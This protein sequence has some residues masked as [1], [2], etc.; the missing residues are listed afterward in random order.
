MGEGNQIIG[1]VI[2]PNHLYL[3]LYLHEQSR[4]VDKVIGAGKRF[5]AYHI[6]GQ[7]KQSGRTD[8]LQELSKGVEANE[9][10][11]GKLHNVFKTSFDAKPVYTDKF[12]E[13]KLNYIHHN[14]LRGKWSLA[15]TP[16]DY[17]YSSARFYFTGE[18]GRVKI[19]HY[20]DAGIFETEK[21]EAMR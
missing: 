10:A 9:S 18:Q 1:Y 14:P 13:Q 8:I 11:R 7:L 21:N 16:E 4:T 5:M 17:L 20:R 19:T 6:V 12:A 15:K 3:L 2:M